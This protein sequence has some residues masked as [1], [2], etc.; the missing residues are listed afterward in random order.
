MVVELIIGLSTVT[1]FPFVGSSYHVIVPA[2]GLTQSAIFIVV[3]DAV[4]AVLFTLL[5]PSEAHVDDKLVLL[6]PIVFSASVVHPAG[7]P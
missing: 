5:V 4:E 1:T 6:C 3:Y 2:L 7:L